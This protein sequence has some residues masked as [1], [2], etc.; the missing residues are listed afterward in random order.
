MRAANGRSAREPARER[1]EARP[2]LPG[3]ASRP[4]GPYKIEFMSEL[5]TLM[6]H[7]GR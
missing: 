1:G 5:S 4:Q 6:K 7:R 3:V 2:A